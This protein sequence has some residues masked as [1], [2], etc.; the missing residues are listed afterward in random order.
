[1]NTRRPDSGFTLLELLVVVFIIGILVT[2]FTLSVGLTGGDRDLEREV[3]RLEALIK[4]ASEEALMQGREIGM[5]FYVDGYE[6]ASY[7]EDFLDYRDPDPEDAAD[8]EGEK[9]PGTSEWVI[10]G[11]HEL[12]G[13]RRLPEQ[14]ELELEIDGRSIVLKPI[15]EKTDDDGDSEKEYRPQVR[16]FSSGDLLPF[17]IRFS[18]SFEN[19]GTILEISAD[20]TVEITEEGT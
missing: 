9:N 12:L 19:D 3:D 6:F 5:R 2:M 15:E 20:G 11:Q 14:I 8:L 10:L 16:I 18:R 7:Q 13:P 17:V 1:M 4:L